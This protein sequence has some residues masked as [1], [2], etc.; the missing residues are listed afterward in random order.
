MDTL[1]LLA[2]ESQSIFWDVADCTG[3]S[4]EAIAERIL[5]YGTWA[6]VK[7]LIRILGDDFFAVV[8]PLVE[9][10]RSIFTP[11]ERTFIRHLIRH[12]HGDTE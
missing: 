11:R 8:S 4:R 10:P 7:S 6:E 9:K 2:A 12:A 1:H 5:K 3:L